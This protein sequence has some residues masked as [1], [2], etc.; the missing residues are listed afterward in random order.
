MIPAE[1]LFG[2]V[3]APSPENV[4][5]FLMAR[6]RRIE[7]RLAAMERAAAALGASR[8]EALAALEAAL[9]FLD[10]SGALHTET[11]KRAC[12]R[13]CGRGWKPESERFSPGWSTTMPRR[14]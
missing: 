8:E 4:E 14:A 7:Q 1:Q 6:H 3:A 11:K 10:T 9:A 13:A 5:E 12:S 2:A